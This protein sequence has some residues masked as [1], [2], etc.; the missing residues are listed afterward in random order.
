MSSIEKDDFGE[1]AEGQT[2][3]IQTPP[4]AY[5]G[6]LLERPVPQFDL[7]V[8]E[9]KLVWQAKIRDIGYFT[10]ELV[11]FNDGTQYEDQRS[12]P[13]KTRFDVGA[14]MTTPWC[15]RI[16]G[17]PTEV[18][19]LLAAQ[20]IASDLVGPPEFPVSLFSPRKTLNMLSN[21]RH[22]VSNSHDAAAQLTLAR[23]AATAGMFD[24]ETLMALGYSRGWMI[25]W[26]LLAQD[27]QFGFDI[28][29]SDG[30]DPCLV[31]KA[32][33]DDLNITDR[34]TYTYLPREVAAA[35][36]AI[37]NH[38]L[39]EIKDLV[40]TLHGMP[41]FLQHV[42][43]G[44]ALFEGQAGWQIPNIQ[45]DKVGVVRLYDKSLGNQ[46]EILKTVLASFPNLYLIDREG[47]HASGMHPNVRKAA[48][49]RI[50]LAQNL[51]AEGVPL[52]SVDFGSLAALPI[53]A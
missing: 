49:G 24:E 6:F 33:Q 42:A 21:I 13:D 32:N 31:V 45:K 8:V 44:F 41:K 37:Q 16:P 14:T 46:R 4:A 18:Q 30:T 20:G 26:D 23:D 11:T 17:Y 52:E 34:D 36:Y 22:Y 7:E 53:A 39:A 19:K 9:R 51:H 1:Q 43:V 2:N 40:K 27:E 35:I 48:V 3:I 38:S 12:M 15:T 47:L 25:G 28:I 50:V 10:R 29:Y 5:G